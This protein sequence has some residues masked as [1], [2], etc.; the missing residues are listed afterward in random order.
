MHKVSHLILGE[1]GA[2]FGC[3]ATTRERLWASSA[4]KPEDEVQRYHG[5][6]F[7]CAGINA[8]RSGRLGEQA[9]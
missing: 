7:T 6:Q 9:L 1:Y 4:R 5:D 2:A 3:A 8:L